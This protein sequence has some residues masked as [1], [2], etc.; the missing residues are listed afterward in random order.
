MGIPV[1]L[2]GQKETTVLGAALFALFGT[3]D[4]NSPYDVR[5]VINYN[6]QVIEPSP[7]SKIYQDYYDKYLILQKNLSH[8]YDKLS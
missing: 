7:E 5:D 4:Y 1:K 3:G 8:T 2:I 6:E